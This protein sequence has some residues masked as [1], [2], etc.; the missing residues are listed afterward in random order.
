MENNSEQFKW[1]VYI[2]ICSDNDKMYIGVHKTSDPNKFDG[3]I[4]NGFY[5]GNTI[6]FPK[7]AYSYALKKHGY[8]KFHRYI[9]KVFDNETDALKLEEYLVD[10]EFVKRRDTYNTAIGGGVNITYKT[11]FQYDLNGNF[12]KE[13]PSRNS[14]LEYYKSNNKYGITEAVKN[15]VSF[16]DS[17]WTNKYEKIDISEYRVSTKG[18]I[19]CYDNNGNLL[20]TFQNAID[21]SKALKISYSFVKESISKKKPIRDMYFVKDPST[22]FEVIK[23]FEEN[24]NKLFDKCVSLY[25]DGN[26]YRTFKCISD[27][28]KLLNVTHKDVKKAILNSTDLNGYY[29]SYGFSDIYNKNTDPCIKVNQYDLEGNFIKQ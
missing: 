1:I 15:K 29:I 10:L 12:L 21:A 11:F 28:S 2:T 16:L 23:T 19:Y 17:Y 9:L 25:V 14:I 20:N 27:V 24:S 22:I 26:R 8:N 5:V 6:N 13:W 3:Y 4:G 7:T 18:S